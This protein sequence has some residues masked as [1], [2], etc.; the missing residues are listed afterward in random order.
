MQK[1]LS[2]KLVLSKETLRTLSQQNLDYVQG[3]L[4]RLC[5]TQGSSPTES[6]GSECFCP[7]TYT[8]C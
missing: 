2:R 4:S 7:P 5:T 8:G 3:G 1:K 6:C